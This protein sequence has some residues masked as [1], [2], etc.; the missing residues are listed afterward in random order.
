MYR[1]AGEVW[2]G[3]AKNATEGL[4]TPGRIVPVTVL[5]LLGQVVPFVFAAHW[6]WLWASGA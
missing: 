6:G 4:A 3:L 5:L 1:S 2:S